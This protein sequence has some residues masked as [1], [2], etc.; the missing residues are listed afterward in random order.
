MNGI[1]IKYLIVDDDEIARIGIEQEATKFPFLQ[2][3]SSCAHPAEALEL[4]RRFSP[5]V[6]FLDIGMPDI[7][8]IELLRRKA[9]AGALPVLITSH[10]D[11]AL[12]GYELDAFDY[13]LKPVSAERFARCAGRL[14]DFTQLKQKAFAFDENRERNCIVIKQGHD[15]MKLP[16]D[17]ILYLEAMKD[18]TRIKTTAGQYLVLVTLR[19]MLNQLPQDLFLQVHRSYVVNCSKVTAIDKGHVFIQSDSLPTGKLYKTALQAIFT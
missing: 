6:V 13:L 1:S 12:E 16:I 4:I 2:K 5:D 19:G 15:K 14:L 8:G 10:P 11:Y 18:Y 3:I 7:S 17:E 9:I